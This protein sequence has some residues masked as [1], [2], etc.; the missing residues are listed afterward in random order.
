MSWSSWKMEDI[1][2]RFKTVVARTKDPVNF[3]DNVNKEILSLKDGGNVVNK[4]DVSVSEFYLM[5]SIQY[6]VKPS[7]TKTKK[8]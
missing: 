4:V 5:A 2:M 3:D 7:R 1:N 6:D 8:D